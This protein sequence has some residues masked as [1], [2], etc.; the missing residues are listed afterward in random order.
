MALIEQIK[1]MED[2]TSK[3]DS[4]PIS[5]HSGNIHKS[6]NTEYAYNKTNAHKFQLITSKMHRRPIDLNHIWSE[7]IAKEEG[8]TP[9]EEHTED[10][11]EEDLE[12]HTEM[13]T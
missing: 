5:A 9:T 10:H 7:E 6:H 12:G 1:G 13:P 11:S 3:W 2:I 8:L 4:D